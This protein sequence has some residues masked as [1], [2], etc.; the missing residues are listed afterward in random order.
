MSN[1]NLVET[2]A[3]ATG[4][5]PSTTLTP[6][7]TSN[8]AGN[9]NINTNISP[10]TSSDNTG[11][12]STTADSNL[13]P[14]S[15][16][17]CRRRKVRCNKTEPC[18]NCVKAGIECIFPGPGRAPR[19]PRRSPDV[20]LLSRLRRLEGVVESL[21][22]TE[23]IEKLIAARLTD[24]PSAIDNNNNNTPNPSGPPGV[25]NKTGQA[26]WSLD[27]TQKN[28]VHQE[29][30][31]L[32]ID[33][34]KS[35]YMSDRMYTSLGTQIEELEQILESP[36]EED[37]E[38][39]TSPEDS[40]QSPNSRNH[41]GFLFGYSSLAHSLRN[42]H[43]TPT[44]AFILWKTYEQNVAPLLMV[45][46]KPTVR[47][48]IINAAM[49]GDS[50]DKSNEAL[51]FVIY[52]AAVISMPPEQCLAELGDDRD[53][54]IS[55][56]RFATEQALA[57]ANL[58]N[59]LN[60]N[61]L[62]AAVLFTSCVHR[63]DHNRFVWTMASVILRLATGLG[64]HR[65][66]THFGLSPFETEMRRRLWWHI[67]IADVRTSEDHGT[68]PMI[69]EWMYDT[70][71][72]LNINDDDINPESKT[73]P[74]ERAAF[75]DMTF[76]L[77]RCHVSKNYRHLIH[78]PLGKNSVAPTLEDRKKTVEGL[79]NT[80][81]E[82]FVKYCDMQEP[83]QWACATMARLVVAKLWLVVHHPMIKNN[84]TS[85]SVEDRNR[86]LLTSIEVIEFTRLMETSE[87]TRRWGWLLG[88]YVQWHAIA[89]VLAELC[90]RPRCPGVDRAWLAIDSTFH[91]W[92]R[93][94]M[95]KKGSLWRP[96]TKLYNK[97]QA[98]RAKG[99]GPPGAGCLGMA[100]NLLDIQQSQLQQHQHQ[101]QQQPQPQQQQIS[102]PQQSKPDQQ[103][104][105]STSNSPYQRDGN[106]SQFSSPGQL[107]HSSD[108][109]Y[110]ISAPF[111]QT[112][113]TSKTDTTKPTPE[114]NL[115]LSK[116]MP[117]ILSDFM[118]AYTMAM[119]NTSGDHNMSNM[120]N[121]SNVSNI[122]TII[123][124]TTTNINPTTNIAYP[125]T[126]TFSANNTAYM[127]PND[128]IWLQDKPNA[129]E[130]PMDWEQFDD[131]MRDFQQEF[132]QVAG[133]GSG[134][135]QIRFM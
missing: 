32:V 113:S 42:Y 62:Q 17:T 94:S 97:A 10:S 102:L 13:N 9:T 101:H 5:I 7:A 127:N 70:R 4:Y 19:K 25:E 52:L 124:L 78:I 89:F 34:S 125:T 93:K 47:N 65:D 50:L 44:Q 84:L 60:I 123:P 92:E 40:S 35:V 46:H 95:G 133:L 122:N 100:Q 71:M 98:S 28:E 24:N 29:L 96:L 108:P 3:N 131:V 104:Q 132:E 48:L 91:E 57:R 135:S 21:G 16:V 45:V 129:F 110:P 103:W 74:P 82:K 56:F 67:V 117:D 76:T 30:G 128:N 75:T 31:R 126:S 8:I 111:I 63:L 41:D 59:S 11:A 2:P 18:S 115:D 1:N 88:S 87:A 15:C 61:L 112:P 26:V 107:S 81:N 69:N 64:L 58:L 130:M 39:E 83:L 37:V 114:L 77:I 86:I 20:E 73:F 66:G 109:K 23:A 12:A 134:D 49:N 85:L 119:S 105:K 6:F 14:R 106:M 118:P 27:S 68:D 22:G 36:S 33:D 121:M 43:P 55:R 99:Y 54:T 38:N 79:H 80:L 72:P 51:V 116:N 53:T 90:V 120:S